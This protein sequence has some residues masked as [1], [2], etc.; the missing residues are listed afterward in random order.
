MTK[1]AELLNRTIEVDFVDINVGCPIDLVYKKVAASWPWTSTVWVGQEP[2]PWSC[3]HL[4]LWEPTGAT[5]PW[6]PH[7]DGEGREGCLA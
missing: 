3:S 6:F 7:L 5:V 1:C 2:G 4:G